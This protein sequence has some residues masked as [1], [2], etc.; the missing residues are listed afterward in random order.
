MASLGDI[1]REAREARGLSPEEVERA[2]RIRAK[3][4]EALE[5]QQFDEL[6]GE[7]Y[8][9]GFLR[10]YA[11]FLG[12]PVADVAAA[13]DAAQAL[14]KGRLPRLAPASAPAPKAP[15]VVD[16]GLPRPLG[17]PE[18]RV[19]RIEASRIQPRQPR[20][21]LTPACAMRPVAP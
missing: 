2:T 18:A 8:T 20:P 13:Y 10:N 1:L 5:Q 7:V 15:P 21:R 3:Y 16:P 12:L 19:S 17:R 9:R 6:P 14:P 11:L 4:V